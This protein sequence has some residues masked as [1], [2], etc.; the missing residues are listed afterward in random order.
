MSAIRAALAQL[1]DLAADVAA[2]DS[3][4][5]PATRE[6]Y[7]ANV[8]AVLQGELARLF[9]GSEV[10]FFVPKLGAEARRV[11]EER[12][13]DALARGEAP[14]SVARR[15]GVSERHARRVRGRFGG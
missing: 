1:L 10:T 7:R 11:R 12:I 3:R 2:R 9:G 14:A 6:A 4:I 8:R 13:A 15:E 5:P